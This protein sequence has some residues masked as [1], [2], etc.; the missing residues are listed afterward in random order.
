MKKTLC[1]LLALLI[2]AA[3]PAMCFAG[4]NTRDLPYVYDEA[5]ILSES[6]FNRLEKKVKN[7]V[8][9]YDMDLAII[10]YGD[11]E[12]L[13]TDE[14]V[15]DLADYL[16]DYNGFGCGSDDSGA[17]LLLSMD[18]NCRMWWTS[19]HA[20]ARDYFTEDNINYIDDNIW[21]DMSSGKY[22]RALETYV[23]LV[24]ELYRNGKFP[25][26]Q[27]YTYDPNYGYTN[28][29]EPTLAEK[30]STGGGIGAVLGAVVGLVSKSSAKKSMKT[31]SQAYSA[32]NYLDTDSLMLNDK[33]DIFLYRTESR[34]RI[35]SSSQGSSRSS[36]GGHPG[37][38]SSYSSGH[39]S[40]SGRT[41]SG[42]GRRF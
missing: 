41:H 26:N 8:D 10:I 4:R 1:I 19:V 29:T 13:R 2:A 17:L 6:E 42:G 12:G 20:K 22:A 27:G 36:S 28:Y 3:F 9:S 7:V 30:L 32:A 37:G 38:R 31:V 21:P 40:S 15:R 24:D 14:E 39:S 33:R 23:D 11:L 16:Y 35:Q 25:I 34:Q 5:G 18:P